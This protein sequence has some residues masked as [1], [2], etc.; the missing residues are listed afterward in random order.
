MFARLAVLYIERKQLLLLYLK[1]NNN[2]QSKVMGMSVLHIKSEVECRVF[3]FGE[4]K[5]IATPGKHFNLLVRK[6]IQE[7]LFVDTS[8]ITIKCTKMLSIENE[9]YDYILEVPMSDFYYEHLEGLVYVYQNNN[10]GD[11]KLKV[12][13]G[14]LESDTE[15]VIHGRSWYEFNIGLSYYDNEDYG[16]A[17]DWFFKASDNGDANAMLY[18]GKCYEFGLGVNKI[19]AYAAKWYHEAAAWGQS[20]AQLNLGI[21]YSKGR[22]VK[23]NYETAV[24]WLRQAA[25][26]GEVDAMV[27]LGVKYMNGEG[28]PKNYNEAVRW[29]RMSAERGSAVGQFNLGWCYENGVVENIDNKEALKWYRL[30]DEQNYAPATLNIG[31]C[32]MKGLGV[33][34][35]YDIA[36]TWFQKVVKQESGNETP[37]QKEAIER[38]KKSLKII[39][40]E[41]SKISNIPLEQKFSIREFAELKGKPTKTGVLIVKDQFESEWKI[42]G[43]FFGNQPVVFTS[44]ILDEHSGKDASEIAKDIICNSSQY[45]V[46]RTTFFTTIQDNPV[47]QIIISPQEKKSETNSIK[48]QSSPEQLQKDRVRFKYL[49]FDTETTGVPKDDN[50]PA[51]D[52]RNWPR[53][54]QLAWIL[55]DKEGNTLSSSCSIIKPEGFTIPDDAAKVHG[56]YTYTAMRDGKPLKNVIDDFLK[57]AAEARCLVGHNVSFDQ[58]IVGAELCRLGIKDTISTVKAICTMEAGKEY[59]EIPGGYYGYKPPKLQE[60]YQK[61]FGT[62]FDNAH[63]AMADV[64]ATKKCFFELKRL[65]ILELLLQEAY[66]LL[67]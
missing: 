45:C 48:G 25:E 34:Q 54:V 1:D 36:T 53:L 66:A 9:D 58:K 44:K 51:S 49:F 18:I 27:N 37:T 59:C 17:I 28:V 62:T 19:Y 10:A 39:A 7:F 42:K 35:N 56:I 33:I 46:E 15:I 29:T 65:E 30:A 6:G 55:T 23:Q 32:Y 3:L 31:V 8:N 64:K 50:A 52:I 2:S 61:L 43:M 24:Y 40:D 5:G 38:A 11:T 13:E 57:A 22:G 26:Q 20:E 63:D 21:L 14:F 4:E 41:K 16:K 47:Y 67:N 60:L 12:K